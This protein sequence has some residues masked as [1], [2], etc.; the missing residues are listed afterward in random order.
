MIRDHRPGDWVPPLE[1][2]YVIV[3]AATLTLSC[4]QCREQYGDLILPGQPCDV[5]D[6]GDLHREEWVCHGSRAE[7]VFGDLTPCLRGC[8]AN[9]LSVL[10]VA[11][12]WNDVDWEEFEAW[13]Y[14][15]VTQ[16]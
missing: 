11:D 14:D 13:L 3:V 16:A 1:D 10:E 8:W 4:V 9:A 15:Y 5:R 7:Q 2:P 6:Y 12:G